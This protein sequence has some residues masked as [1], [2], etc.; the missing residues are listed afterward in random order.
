MYLA[1][2]NKLR[3]H[4]LK[5]AVFAHPHQNNKIRNICGYE[6]FHSNTVYIKSMLNRNNNSCPEDYTYNKFVPSC[7]QESEVQQ[8]QGKVF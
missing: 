4:G 8:I 3:C 2:A 5:L 7:P 6:I 1:C